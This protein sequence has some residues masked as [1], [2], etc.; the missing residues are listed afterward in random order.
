ME[1]ST[2]NRSKGV[3]TIRG[4]G[5]RQ[6][7]ME[8]QNSNSRPQHSWHQGFDDDDDDD[9]VEKDNRGYAK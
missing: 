2:D 5:S 4:F 8:K 6:I 3:Q 9:D 1:G 7:K